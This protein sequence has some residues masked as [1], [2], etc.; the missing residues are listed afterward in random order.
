MSN[1]KVRDKFWIFA[2]K[3]HDDDPYF[4]QSKDGILTGCEWSRI[5]PAEGAFMLGTPNLMMIVSDGIP[6]PYSRDAFGYLESFCRLKRVLWS[7]TGSGGFRN[8]NE[9]E[10]ICDMSEEYPNLIG[11]FFDDVTWDHRHQCVRKP[12]DCKA[13]FDNARKAFDKAGKPME[14]WSNCYSSQ[15]DMYPKDTFENV[16]VM[17]IWG[18]DRTSKE[19]YLNDFKKYEEVYPEKRKA[20]GIYLY[21]Y[22][23]RKAWELDIF[24]MECE[25]ALELLKEGRIDEIIFLTNCT[26]GIGL[27]TELWLRDW[28]DEVGDEELVID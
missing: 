14:I 16:D 19:N 10:F 27:E 23:E 28:I 25:T 12:A 17:T 21:H 4:G 8:G 11:G 20:I 24:K 22:I 15:F 2:S 6:V 9:E 3:A 18:M 26:M 13:L 5:T 1:I 7:C